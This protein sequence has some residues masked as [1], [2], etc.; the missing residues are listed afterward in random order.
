MDFSDFVEK[1]LGYCEVW[2]VALISVIMSN[3]VGFAMMPFLA[4]GEAALVLDVIYFALISIGVYY[5]VQHRDFGFKRVEVLATGFTFSAVSLLSFLLSTA[6]YL[7]FAPSTL[8][9][10][11]ASFPRI[12]QIFLVSIG[13]LILIRDFKDRNNMLYLSSTAAG[14]V[15]AVA[16]YSILAGADVFSTSLE[17]FQSSGIFGAVISAFLALIGASYISDIVDY[18]EET[19]TAASLVVLGSLNFGFEYLSDYLTY[20]TNPQVGQ[21]LMES[22]LGVGTIDSVVL[23]TTG[24][25]YAAGQYLNDIYSEV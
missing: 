13:L 3:A 15:L 11:I 14:L 9:M 19:V 2:A 24:I 1:Y 18:R 16:A 6:G 12:F 25:V 5:L 17:Y 23:A 7:V 21:M 8:P 22:A 20:L 4:A 10:S